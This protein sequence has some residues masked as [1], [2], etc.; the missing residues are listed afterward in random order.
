MDWNQIYNDKNSGPRQRRFIPNRIKR[1]RDNPPIKPEHF[2]EL[3]YLIINYDYRIALLRR[4]EPLLSEEIKA[5]WLEKYLINPPDSHNAASY[6][7]YKILLPFFLINPNSENKKI[8]KYFLYDQLILVLGALDYKFRKYRQ[9]AY[10]LF[11]FLTP[12]FVKLN[13]TYRANTVKILTENTTKENIHDVKCLMMKNWSIIGNDLK[14]QFLAVQF[15]RQLITPKMAIG[16]F[17]R[18]KDLS[19]LNEKELRRLILTLEKGEYIL[20]KLIED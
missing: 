11:R 7:I 6:N 1:F 19:F 13:A 3:E 17:R 2:S 5:Q 9:R 14:N 15:Q 12:N 18:R 8:D 16:I 20:G 10:Y 4:Y